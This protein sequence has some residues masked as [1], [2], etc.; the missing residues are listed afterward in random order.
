MSIR[1]GIGKHIPSANVPAAS[2]IHADDATLH[3]RSGSRGAVF[4][5]GGRPAE[6]KKSAR[7]LFRT[8]AAP[9]E[10]G[11]V[12]ALALSVS[13]SVSI[14]IVNKYLISTLGFPYVLSLIHI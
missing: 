7:A 8:D 11:T 6:G 13:S 2:A 9:M 1:P 10:L 3:E 12:G 5:F 4:V 14:V